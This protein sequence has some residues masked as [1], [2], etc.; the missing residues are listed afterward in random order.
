MEVSITPRTMQKLPRGTSRAGRGARS[1]TGPQVMGEAQRRK[2]VRV[3]IHAIWELER[4]E[5][6][7]S[8]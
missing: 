7:S 2:A 4:S 8:V 1:K 3:P 5:R 6:N